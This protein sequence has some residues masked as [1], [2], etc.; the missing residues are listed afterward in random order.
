MYESRLSVTLQ[1]RGYNRR[2]AHN[3]EPRHLVA[4]DASYHGAGVNSESQLLK[5]KKIKEW[6]IK[7]KCEKTTTTRTQIG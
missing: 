2:L 7:S 4:N 3:Y 6:F 5:R 1:F